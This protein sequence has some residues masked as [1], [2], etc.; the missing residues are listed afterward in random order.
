MDATNTAVVT[1]SYDALNRLISSA[2]GGLGVSYSYNPQGIRT[3]RTVG[4]TTTNYLLD[5]GNVVGEVTG[6]ATATYL[7]G[8]NLIS[9]GTN[10]YL[11]NAH[12]DVT[13][14][15]NASGAITKTYKY[16][17]FGNQLNTVAD[18]S[19]PFRYC[20]EY[21]DS[22]TGNY[23]LRARYYD[24]TVGRFTQ[25]DTHWNTAN[26]IYGDTMQKLNVTVD[27]A[28]GE[29]FTAIPQLLA[30]RQAGN[31]YR[32]AVNNPISFVDYS[33][34]QAITVYF[35]QNRDFTLR[36]GSFLFGA[37]ISIMLIDELADDDPP[38]LYAK[39]GAKGA[40]H[41]NSAVSMGGSSP[42]S[43]MPPNNNKDPKYRGGSS[44]EK[45]GIR[46]DY[47]S[48]GNGKGNVHVH[49]RG[50]KYIYDPSSNVLLTEAGTVA[51]RWV[52]DLLK[53][54]EIVKAIGKGLYYLSN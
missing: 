36:A 44:Y 24:P 21:Y 37:A 54:A 14:L 33:G 46:V 34:E 23:Y 13:M 52:Q 11:H 17:A 40:N 7:R 50:G 12:G 42:A 51:P 30:I 16:D 38:I 18:D 15:A 48:Y 1:H 47:E 53:V 41:P 28:G 6:D 39:K 22:E 35:D 31:L 9:D 3:S 29:Y 5:G 32:Y 43:P 20:G 10:Y 49:V 45:N 2:V 8:L 4:T 19:N 25:Q 27:A 26:M